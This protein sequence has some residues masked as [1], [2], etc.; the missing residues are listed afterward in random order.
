[1]DA[2]FKIR[3]MNRPA[4][5]AFRGIDGLIGRDFEE[6][7]HIAWP[8]EVAKSVVDRFKHTLVTGEP[9]AVPEFSE[10]RYDRNVREYYD[11]Q[12]H[13]IG[14]PD[15]RFGVVCYFVDISA[16]VLAEQS[17][18]QG[19][20]R[21]RFVMESIPQK[22]LTATPE[23]AVD[24]YNPQWFEFTGLTFDQIK[25]SGWKQF[26]HP[27]DLTES[28]RAWERSIATGEPCVL[29]QRFRRA[30]GVYRWHLSRT[31]AMR[32]AQGKVSLWIGSNTDI[33]EQWEAANRLRQYAAETSE[34]NHQKSEFLAML[35]HELRNP[36]API[37][38]ALQILQSPNTNGKADAPVI[39][40]LERQVS[41]MVRLVD[42]LLDA[43]RISLGKIELR[44][45]HIELTSLV[46]N[47][48]D[49]VRP[50]CESMGHELTLNLPAGP[51]YLKA[52]PTRLTQVVG[53]L[54]N[55]ASKFTPNGG[56]IWVSVECEGKQALIRVRDNGVGIAEV[57]LRRIFDMFM[58][59]D[60]SLERAAGGL[61][62]GLTLVKRLVELHHGTVEV[63]SAGL[64][65]GS[66]FVVRLPILDD[67]GLR[68]VAAAAVNEG[69]RAPVRRI[70]VVDDNEDSAASLAMLLQLSG[71]Q[72][73]TA[74]D[75][76][77]AVDAAVAFRPEVILLDIGM[78]NLNGYEACRRIRAQASGKDIM[79]IATTGWGQAHA[80]EASK[81]A[82]FDAHLV[83]PVNPAELARLL[84]DAGSP[85]RGGD[86]D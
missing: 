28:V 69:D 36:L 46:T 3:L 59:V 20:N 77:E 25:D 72:T 76:L 37:G 80:R 42:D 50:L 7:V 57:Q 41:Q 43:S 51:I 33:H 35:A 21:L 54:L 68:S 29:E 55:N 66:E 56:S 71:H 67:T 61:G 13:R 49:V 24:Y 75:G 11:W 32:D 4:L 74:H 39:A 40:M 15:G 10:E 30:D 17:L 81:A 62:I 18:R 44:F 70:L 12:I 52:D 26:I 82:G 85:G 34:A 58:Q 79:I 53:N 2:D 38:N 1:M 6:V 9:Y 60:T 45:G 22:I 14:L 63:K 27:D 84:A 31:V 16:R 86:Q 23:G 73:R 19:E 8:P 48:A 83:K 47:A 65:Q 5:A 78:P 64:G